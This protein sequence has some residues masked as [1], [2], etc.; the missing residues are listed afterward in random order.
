M[1]KVLCLEEESC[2]VQ[3]LSATCVHH[4]CK[5]KE[6]YET[7]LAFAACPQRCMRLDPQCTHHPGL[8]GGS[9]DQPQTRRCVE[10]PIEHGL[11]PGPSHWG[12][13]RFSA[14]CR[15]NAK[16]W[17]LMCVQNFSSDSYLECAN[18]F[19]VNAGIVVLPENFSCA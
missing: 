3:C 4:H 15:Q 1:S 14:N 10:V 7:N 13:P 5:K 18:T 16:R 19:H 12:N 2:P 9:I 6:N 17:L 11:S 8:Y